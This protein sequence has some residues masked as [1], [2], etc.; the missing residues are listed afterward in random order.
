MI[1]PSYIALIMPQNI[2]YPEGNVLC[3]IYI[4]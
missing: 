2:Q 1:R 3:Y 4:L